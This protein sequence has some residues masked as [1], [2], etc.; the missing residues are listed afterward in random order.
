MEGAIRRLLQVRDNGGWDE[1]SDRGDRKDMF[2]IYFGCR[3]N[4]T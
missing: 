3:T 1:P 2:D 4:R